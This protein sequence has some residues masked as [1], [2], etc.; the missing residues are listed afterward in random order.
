MIHGFS[1]ITLITGSV[2]VLAGIVMSKF[3]PKGINYTTGYR[4]N[5]S[6]KNEDTWKEGNRAGAKNMIYS[7]V[8]LLLIS[9]IIYFLFPDLGEKSTFAGLAV[10]IFSAILMIWRTEN[11]LNNTFD[12]NGKRKS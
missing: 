9:A 8:F 10:I 1:L 3:P 5:R 2:F 11:H 12:K 6:M 7:G 4:T